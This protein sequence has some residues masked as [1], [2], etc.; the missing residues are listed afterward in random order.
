M[1]AVSAGQVRARTP[2]ADL[3]AYGGLTLAA[4]GWASAYVAGKVVLAEMAPLVAAAWRFAVAA[5]VLLPFALRSRPG[6]EARPA[7]GALAVL[8]V[9]GGV[10]YP[11]LGW[12]LSPMV[13]AAAMSLSS[14]TVIT[15]A[16]RLRRA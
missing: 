9:C 12:L 7:A 10:L 15:N 4:M 6:R 13:A 8:V 5:V 2:D 16:L 11:W 14:V 3:L 1:D